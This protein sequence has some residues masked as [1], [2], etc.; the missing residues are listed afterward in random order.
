[1]PA[2]PRPQ[3]VTAWISQARAGTPEAVELLCRH[4]EPRLE[5][6]VER[7]MGASA[8]RWVE[9]ADIVQGVLF[10][11]VPRL[12]ELPFEL[13]AED[14]ARRLFRTA[15]S[16]IRDA[17]RRHAR[18]SGESYAPEQALH[19]RG[20][21]AHPEDGSSGSVTQADTRRWLEE[22]VAR[23]P[24]RYA[25]PVRL[26]GL[27]GQS[28]DEAAEVLGIERETVRKRYERARDSLRARIQGRVDA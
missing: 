4:F 25:L 23:L 26:V 16:R 14:L 27:Q 10:E 21:A 2:P 12:R 15:S 28:Y 7:H 8:R 9:P 5:D 17:V 6:Y 24:E 22:L 20:R 13:D 3:D 1:M 18:K 11:V 19:A